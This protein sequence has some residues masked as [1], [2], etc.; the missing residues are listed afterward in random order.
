MKRT[1]LFILAVTTAMSCLFSQTTK[2]PFSKL[3]YKKQV[4][5]TSSKGEFEE[6]H[7]NTDVVE[8]GSVYFNTKSYKVVGYINEEKGKTDVASATSAMSIDP[9]CEKYYWISPYAFCLNNPVNY[10]DP[11]G[12]EVWAI[13]E[14]EN[15]KRHN[16]QYTNGNLYDA[17]GNLYEGNNKDALAI[18]ETLNTIK[19]IDDFT[20]QLIGKLESSDK[21]H[22]IE[23]GDKN[24]AFSFPR[25]VNENV[26]ANNGISTG[27]QITTTL[28]D[29]RIIEGN[30]KS[31]KEADLAHELRHA[32]DRD[33]GLFKGENPGDRSNADKP[34]EQRA[35]GFENRV[36]KAMGLPER[37]TYN[38]KPIAPYPYA[39]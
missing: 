25:S 10:I 23:K 26:I 11:D 3:G 14:D 24:Q 22:Y 31:T 32:Y 30:L 34:Y 1:V 35:V 15:G 39:K 36:R 17:K 20:S 8:I 7:N 33:K 27:S 5:Y 4:M 37:T 21:K 9:L 38:G 19:G 6:F 18:L 28:Q 13:F 2:N 12:R 16:L 29:G